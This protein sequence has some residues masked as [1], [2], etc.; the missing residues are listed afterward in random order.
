MNKNKQRLNIN[1]TLVSS[2][3]GEK[4]SLSEE[5]INALKRTAEV[6]LAVIAVA[7]IATIAITA[8]NV[9]QA[10]DKLFL[11]KHR[12][13]LSTREV[14]QKTSQAFYYLK[15]SGLIKLKKDGNDW[16]IFLTSLGK[17]KISEIQSD[18]KYIAKPKTWNKKWWLVAA[19][20]PTKDYR[21][22]ADL[23]RR[24][25]KELA[26][27]PLQRTLWIYPYD[28][29]NEIQFLAERYH[30]TPFITVMEINRLDKED[31]QKAKHYLK[32]QNLM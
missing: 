28:P 30:I 31:E 4:L 20:I 9:L 2:K 23:L 8:P 22:S 19:D 17:N 29:R 27:F 15:R 18:V 10:V 14:R 7:G 16:K 13:R 6:A 12:R 26:F 32:Q 1:K 21:T 5:Q 24:K 25:L 3:A 11:K